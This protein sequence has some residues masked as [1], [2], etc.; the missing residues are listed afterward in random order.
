MTM[1]PQPHTTCYALQQE[2]DWLK[3]QEKLQKIFTVQTDSMQ[4]VQ[5]TY[6]DSFDSRLYLTQHTVFT[7]HSKKSVQKNL[8]HAVWQTP[9]QQHCIA[10]K[11]MP[12]FFWEINDLSLKNTLKP[13]L[14][15]RALIEQ[16]QVHIQKQVLNI[17]DD[18]QKII[19]RLMFTQYSR[20]PMEQNEIICRLL[21]VFPVKGYQKPVKRLEELL[22]EYHVSV[23]NQPL[24]NLLLN[25]EGK[26]PVSYSNKL[27]LQLTAD[28]P[29]QQAMHA[30]LSRLLQMMR[31]NHAGTCA[32]LDSEFLHDF[33]VAIRRTRS[34]LN[35]IKQVIHPDTIEQFQAHFAWLGQ[36]TSE[37]RDMDVYLLKFDEYKA[38]LPEKVQQDLDLL[39]E[40]L[41]QHHQSAQKTLAEQLQSA[42]YQAIIDQWQTAL[43]HKSDNNTAKNAEKPILTVA[44]NR[45]WKMYQRLLRDGQ[46]IDTDTPSVALH[47]LRKTGKKLRYLIE[48]F[49]SLY[50]EKQIVPLI[51]ALKRL[52]DN[53]GNFQDFEVQSEKLQHFAQQ[54][55]QETPN[56]TQTVMAMGIL[57]ADLLQQ[58]QQ[59]RQDFAQCFN[60]FASQQWQ[61]RFSQLF[62]T[63]QEDKS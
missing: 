7:E 42:K 22:L 21:Q 13:L 15:V 50:P 5:R 31:D 44:N 62:H 33:R 51:K 19:L 58:Q 57:T 10:I 8:C 17:L 3:L 29:A 23:Q 4:T 18:E 20:I 43:S 9:Q 25:H 30:I 61:N 38:R 36:I 35:Q 41:R 11:K 27:N 1:M 55:L 26:N 40:F 16:I 54:L 37:T 53:L 24:I 56:A 34:A 45:I 39:H 49:E 52:Q 28:M 32:D 60:E 47:D 59:T 2:S 12:R 6:Y 46:A 63:E 14:N 48:F